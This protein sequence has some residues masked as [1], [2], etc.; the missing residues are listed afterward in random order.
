MKLTKAQSEIVRL[1]REG[2][3]LKEIARE[4]GKSHATVR[5]QV[6]AARERSGCRS[7]AE[8]AVKTYEAD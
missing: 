4:L 1:L 5:K 3:N 2:K 8:M 7:N 6:F